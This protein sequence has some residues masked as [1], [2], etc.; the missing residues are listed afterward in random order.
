M[1]SLVKLE[2]TQHPPFEKIKQVI[3]MFM[4]SILVKIW[5]VIHKIHQV[6]FVHLLLYRKSENELIRDYDSEFR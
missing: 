6:Q 3:Q 1:D 4:I 5:N 2:I